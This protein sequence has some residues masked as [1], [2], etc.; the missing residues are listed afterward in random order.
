MKKTKMKATT[1]RRS[2]TTILIIAICASTVAFYY[3]QSQ[4][5]TYAISTRKV[6]SESTL[7]GTGTAGIT[8]F[9]EEIAEAQVVSQKA[10]T[11]TTPIQDYQT[12]AIKDLNKYAANAGITITDYSFSQS[13]SSKTATTLPN[14]VGVSSVTI[15]LNNPVP[16]SNL[17][18]FLKS[19]ENSTPKIQLD[20]INISPDQNNKN[21]V[22]VQPLTIEIYTR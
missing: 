16:Y 22:T 13:T 10:I 5:N 4:L 11:I 19:I 1:L 14:G 2:M 15:T 7:G 3:I 18:Q 6:I 21:A 17:M 8:K 20:S 9:Q 12:Q